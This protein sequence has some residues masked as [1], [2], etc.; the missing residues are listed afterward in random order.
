[1]NKFIKIFN[2][3]YT[4][5]SYAYARI[6]LIGEHTDYT[7]GYVFPKL[8]NYKTEIFICPNKKQNQVYSDMYREKI[9]FINL[10]KSKNNHWSD[11]IKGCFSTINSNFKLPKDKFN[12]F[13]KSNI[14]PNK[15]ISSS[16]ALCV[17][18]IKVL[19]NYYK[20][21]IDNKS[22]AL[23]AQ[24]TET[25]YIG[26]NSGIMD[27]M[28][29]SIGKK[30][31]AFFLNCRTYNYELIN[32]PKNYLFNIIDSNIDRKLRESSYNERFN[33]L[34]KAQLILKTKYLNSISIKEFNKKKFDNAI[35]K[36]RARHV[37]SE[38]E[39]V[40]KAKNAMKD[41]DMD[42]FGQLMN[43]S[44]NSY[45]KNFNA[46]NKIIDN[47]IKRSINCGALGSRLTGG[48]FGGF[49]ISLIRKRNFNQWKSKML[50]FY[51]KNFFLD[52]K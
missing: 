51:S 33:E 47:I 31:K 2:K 14:P 39:R 38:N 13:I 29:S 18:L 32:I 30:N 28:V 52:N 34:K 17:A 43:E 7:G 11:Y 46:S 21:D 9:S 40:L 49:I 15:G 25:N 22:I 1:M 20:I 35:I 8:I 41:G 19:K 42:Y 16:A 6:N 48:G 3:Q 36:K 45:S 24:K 44:H 37:I 12:I 26:I 4:H 27:Q 50:N 10:N 23:L 5:K